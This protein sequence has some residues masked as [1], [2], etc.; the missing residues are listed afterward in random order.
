MLGDVVPTPDEEQC[1]ALEDYVLGGGALLLIA[2]ENSPMLSTEFLSI[3]GDILPVSAVGAPAISTGDFEIAGE[4]DAGMSLTADLTL[5]QNVLGSLPPLA[6][7]LEGIA[8]TAGATVHLL[9]SRAGV[10]RPLLVSEPKNGGMSAV[11]LGFP[12]WRWRLAGGEGERAYDRLLGGLIQYLA[13]E[14]NA[15]PIDIQPDRTVYRAG[16]RPRITI[17]A[18]AAPVSAAVRGEVYSVDDMETPIETFMATPDRNSPG[19][20]R[21]DLGYLPPGEYILSVGEGSPSPASGKGSIVVESSSVEMLRTSCDLGFLRREAA[22][23]GGAVLR[24]GELTRLS[25]LIDLEPDLAVST[26]IRNIRGRLWLLVLIV[27][28]FAIEWLLRK[29]WGLV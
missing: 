28:V 4:G 10:E 11:L 25:G 27:S 12:L 23:T 17:Y 19:V 8:P 29:F 5:D 2:S 21:T 14:R 3:L 16:E 1:S 15:P 20:Y 26:T 22:A 24:P 18:S 9:M 6:G 13:E 7:A